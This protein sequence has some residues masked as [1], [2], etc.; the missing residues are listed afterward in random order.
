MSHSKVLSNKNYS[1]SSNK[2]EKP[3]LI[4][5]SLRILKSGLNIIVCIYMLL[6]MVWMPFYFT[7]G[8]SRIGTN[9]YEFLY[10]VS[11]KV[12]FLF[13][14]VAFLYLL[15][16]GSRYFLLEKRHKQDRWGFRKDFSLTDK[17]ML[18][19]GA[20]VI[21]SYL[22]TDYKEMT[23]Y[24]S[25]W[26]GSNGWYMGLVSQ[27]IFVVV[28]FA[29]SRFWK[30]YKWMLAV[31][32]VVVLA[33]FGLGYLNR[34]GIRPI[35]MQGASMWFISTIG[36]INWYCGY[37][38]PI[39]FGVLYYSWSGAEKKS[40]V[41]GLLLLWVVAG[42]ATL[43]TQ[44]SRSVFLALAAALVTLY[45]L[46]MRSGARM[47]AFFSCLLC[48]GVACAGTC[49]LRTYYGEKY[50]YEDN[51]FDLLTNS[52]AAFGIL[53]VA[54]VGWLTVRL[55]N[56][57]KKAPVKLFTAVGYGGC[58]LAGILVIA[59]LVLGIMNTKNPGSIGALS[60]E[61][62]FQF[63]LSWGSQRGVTLAAGVMCFLDQDLLGKLVGV[64]PDCMAM[65]VHSGVNADLLAMVEEYF[66]DLNLTNAHCEWLTV[67]VNTGILGLVTY[68]GMIISA[69]VRYLKG[70]KN[71]AIVGA[72]GLGILAYTANNMV[73][74]Q[75]S[76]GAITLFLILG[77]GEAYLREA[78]K[79]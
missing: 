72:C 63:N 53:A 33:V 24:G 61:P 68:A 47:Q 55:L 45:L 26:K 5:D 15:L 3:N 77:I 52:R 39:F 76:M 46:S 50:L 79:S 7:D 49:F 51:I 1:N 64:G 44:G 16:L 32:L 60:E 40:W 29:V 22:C 23:D 28:Y 4:E 58:V 54:L 71:S 78:K 42:F 11:T 73:S 17:L 8:Y 19:Y 48:M 38:V 36:N 31:W 10:S 6:V 59:F 66:G 70:G 67:L 34:F 27:L 62:L 65:Y 37:I 20:A 14:P 74:F 75:Q 41:K 30:R 25:A 21:L 56:F 69:I 2:K 18:G 43:L 57:K 35:E 9:K 12:G 13:L